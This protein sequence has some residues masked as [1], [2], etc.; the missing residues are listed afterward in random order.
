MG[1]QL[2]AISWRLFCFLPQQVPI[3][4][5]NE[6]EPYARNLDQLIFYDLYASYHSWHK[7]I[8]VTVTPCPEGKIQVLL[9]S[10]MFPK[11]CWWLLA[12]INFPIK[13]EDMF[14]YSQNFDDLGIY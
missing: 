7:Y 6:I 9:I 14:S 2:V 8:N 3:D 12:N 13:A 10:S 11:P 5:Q 4:S 1:D